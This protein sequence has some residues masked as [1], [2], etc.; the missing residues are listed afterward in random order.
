MSRSVAVVLVCLC[1]FLCG[2]RRSAMILRDP[3][4]PGY[5]PALEI[6]LQQTTPLVLV[7]GKLAFHLLNKH[8]NDIMT[9]T[10]LLPA[11]LQSS[12]ANII[13]RSNLSG[14]SIR[15][16]LL[17]TTEGV[18]LGRAHDNTTGAALN[19]EALT[20]IETDWAPPSKQ[21]PLL[22]LEKAQQ[23]TAMYNHGTLIHVYQSPV[24]VTILCGL[25]CNLGA[26]QSS[27]IPL[28][29]Q[30][31]EP[32]CTTLVESLKPVYEGSAPAYYQ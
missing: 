17:S 18:P 3:L 31:L 6:I 4:S 11:A 10:S 7:A 8:I 21:L 12:L 25:D 2:A 28:L 27:A 15:V 20:A 23:V 14:A 16:I 5:D 32:L 22:G 24:V 13:Q 30:V 19:E 26:V 9:A 1:E 29:K